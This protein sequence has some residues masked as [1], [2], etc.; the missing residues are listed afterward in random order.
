MKSAGNDIVALQAI[1]IQ[2]T[3]SPQF[4]SKFITAHEQSIYQQSQ[5]AAVPFYSFIWLLWCVKESA[6]KY[7][8]RSN[9]D[10]VFSPSKIVIQNINVPV[11]MPDDVSGVW[12]SDKA[13]E[14]FYTGGVL[15]ETTQLYFRLKITA[16]FIASVVNDSPNFDHVVWGIRH[17]ENADNENQSEQVRAFTLAKVEAIINLENI[18]IKKTP[19]GYPY[20]AQGNNELDMPLSLAH[21][22]HFIAFS[23]RLAQFF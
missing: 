12:E 21:H 18:Q 22:G 3:I 15:F 16:N 7:L 6:Y 14:D 20:F 2:R 4:Y 9:P 11:T 17:I 5:F 23:F 10:L 13:N 19:S 1:D 8:K